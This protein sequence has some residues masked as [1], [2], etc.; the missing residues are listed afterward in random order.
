MVA[1]ASAH[2]AAADTRTVTL[3]YARAPG[4]ER[5]PDERWIRQAVSA[6]LGFDPFRDDAELRV[7]A[8]IDSAAQGLV[9]TLSVTDRSGK[10]LGRREL[11]SPAGDCLELA[12]AM[13][14]AIAIAVDP[15]YLSR[16]PPEPPPPDVPAVK[17]EQPAPEPL[18][19]PPP[20]TP[21][22][23]PSSHLSLEAGAGL[24]ASAGISPYPTA[25][26]SLRGR[27]RWTH[28]S[29]GLDAR[30]DL[31]S[32]VAFG[33]GRVKSS[34]LLGSVV[35][36][37]HLGRFAGCAVASFGALQ[38]TG[39]LTPPAHRESSPL[40]LFGVRGELEVPLASRL[41]LKPFAEV[42]VVVTRTTVVSGE[43]PV[44]VT[45][46][47]AGSVGVAIDLLIL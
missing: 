36:C 3:S 47:V 21:P 25:G 8:K 14:L 42:Q 24:L 38:V 19:S 2:A 13:E 34:A 12:S 15:L 1:G 28:L 10:R 35:P 27:L 32:S 9:G 29:V 5:C 7:E 31:Q 37:A 20:E 41:A 4:L 23:P 26:L 22:P 18:K 40:V 17:E 33:D 46:P 30:A 16:P 11:S 39:E 43:A 6:R 45:A 44:W